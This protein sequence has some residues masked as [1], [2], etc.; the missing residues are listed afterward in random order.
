MSSLPVADIED[1]GGVVGAVLV[2]GAGGLAAVEGLAVG[3]GVEAGMAVGA[4]ED[5][6]PVVLGNREAAVVVG[7]GALVG[8][9][10]LQRGAYHHDALVAAVEILVAI[11]TREV[12]VLHEVQLAG[13]VAHGRVAPRLGRATCEQGSKDYYAESKNA[14][15]SHFA[16]ARVSPGIAW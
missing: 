1:T 10:L 12:G 6:V 16:S 5:G 8:D 9:I 4:F 2:E 3:E 14:K 15:R 7:T 13:G 11:A